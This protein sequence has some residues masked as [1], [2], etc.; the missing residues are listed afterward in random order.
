MRPMRTANLRLSFIA[1]A[2]TSSGRFM[3]LNGGDFMSAIATCCS[4][5]PARWWCC[6]CCFCC[7]CCCCSSADDDDENRRWCWRISS[8]DTALAVYKT[9]SRHT[10]CA[11]AAAAA[12][13][14]R[15]T[16]FSSYASS[17]F[18]SLY[19]SHGARYYEN[20]LRAHSTRP[21]CRRRR[22]SGFQLFPTTATTCIPARAR[23]TPAAHDGDDD[24]S[25]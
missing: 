25:K 6:G 11:A 12:R 3:S 8:Q 20:T 23:T 24:D 14:P 4:A 22:C 13:A 10:P 19:L 5:Q 9:L 17:R 2:T 7:C 18:L 15:R 16:Q 21:H 1:I